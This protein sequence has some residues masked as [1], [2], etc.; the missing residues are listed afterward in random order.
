MKR[1]REIFRKKNA[2]H[3]PLSKHIK[4]V[5]ELNFASKLEYPNCR[6]DIKEFLW[7]QPTSYL[8]LLKTVSCGVLPSVVEHWMTRHERKSTVMA[9]LLRETTE[10]RRSL[11][12]L[13]WWMIHRGGQHIATANKSYQYR[14]EKH[15]VGWKL[16]RTLV[17]TDAMI[18]ACVVL[19]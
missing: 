14:I 7:M 4:S 3:V 13:D 18:A 8:S 12:T 15:S 9:E 6:S 10:L 5:S 19:S 17:V 2:D 11:N 1:K 16:N